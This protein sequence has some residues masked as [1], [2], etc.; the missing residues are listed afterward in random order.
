ML[1]SDYRCAISL[2]QFMV[3][4]DEDDSGAIASKLLDLLAA[5]LAEAFVADLEYFVEEQYV[6]ISMYGY[7]KSQ[8]LDHAGRKLIYLRALELLQF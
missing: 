4:A 8:P 1:E 6:G 7:G 5:F 3:M 2:D